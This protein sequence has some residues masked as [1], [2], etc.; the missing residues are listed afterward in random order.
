MSL[1]ERQ[2][3]EV[4]F[5]F[6]LSVFLKGI[7]ALIEIIGGFLLL[8]ISANTLTDFIFYLTADE[9]AGDS[10]DFFANTLLHFSQSFSEAGQSFLAFYLLSHGIVKLFLVAAL[11]KKKLWAYPLSLYV[12]GV[13]IAYQLYRYLST[14]SMLLILLT[15]F[16]LFVMV[17]IYLE[18]RLV[19]KTK[20]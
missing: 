4:H 6:R 7:H 5:A 19:K 11:L 8:V 18:Y 3:K 10:N 13:F 1:T 9:I 12:L 14:H 20:I 2:T 15:I 17:L 16:D